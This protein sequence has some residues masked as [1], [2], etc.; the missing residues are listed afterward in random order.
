MCHIHTAIHVTNSYIDKRR[1][2]KRVIWPHLAV[3][4]R[5]EQLRCRAGDG[6]G[7]HLGCGSSS[8]GGRPVELLLPTTDDGC[9]DG[10]DQ[11][12]RDGRREGGGRNGCGGGGERRRR[13]GTAAAVG[14]G[15]GVWDFLTLGCHRSG[16]EG[17]WSGRRGLGVYFSVERYEIYRMASFLKNKTNYGGYFGPVHSGSR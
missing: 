10:W 3:G 8:S 6:V 11:R 5:L 12:R 4:N 16:R 14:D 7:A 15:G 2:R 1:Q 9:G 13:W 17:D